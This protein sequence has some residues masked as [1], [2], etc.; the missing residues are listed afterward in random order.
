[1]SDVI[2]IIPYLSF[3]NASGYLTNNGSDVALAL[4]C[5]DFIWGKESKSLHRC[6]VE[7]D[8]QQIPFF[9][10]KRR[11]DDGVELDLFGTTVLLVGSMSDNDFW[12]KIAKIII[13]GENPDYDDSRVCVRHNLLV[14][15]SESI[16]ERWKELRKEMQ[17]VFNIKRLTAF[18]QARKVF[19]GRL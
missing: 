3:D 1:M 9:N 5:T 12:K 7:C 16:D 10:L 14:S 17:S 8:R 11:G 6:E 13:I 19:N 4:F 2:E 18:Q 15:D